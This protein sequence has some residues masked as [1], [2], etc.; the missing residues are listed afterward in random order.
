MMLLGSMSGLSDDAVAGIIV[1]VI[2]G[3]FVI[4]MI[5]V[6][7]II[8]CRKTIKTDEIPRQDKH[9]LDAIPENE[10]LIM[11]FPSAPTQNS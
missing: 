11:I 10:G 2:V 3:F 7:V 1:G 5:V 8:R 4:A 9:K 6:Y